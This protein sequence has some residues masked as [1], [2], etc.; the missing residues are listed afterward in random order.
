MK[1]ASASG[2]GRIPPRGT[3]DRPARKAACG[4]NP[5][6]TRRVGMG[7]SYVGC[8]FHCLS[9][10]SRVLCCGRSPDRATRFVFCCGRSPD[11]ATRFDRK[12]SRCTSLR[13]ARETCG[14]G[15]VR[16]Q[17]THAQQST[18]HLAFCVSS[19]SLPMMLAFWSRREACATIFPSAPTRIAYGNKPTGN[20][21]IESP[22]DPSPATGRYV[23]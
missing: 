19:C 4:G 22:L 10:C 1:S 23:G 3:S 14:Q 18:T 9:A 8:I 13:H 11:R 5:S 12:V 2:S 16:G 15:M 20:S 7:K 21:P 17:E 6:L